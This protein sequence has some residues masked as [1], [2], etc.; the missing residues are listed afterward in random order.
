MKSDG[1]S[2][3]NFPPDLLATLGIP[4]IPVALFT[5]WLLSLRGWQWVAAYCLALLIATVG[6]IYLFRAKLPLYRRHRFFTFGS[7]H[8]P[9]SSIPLYRRGCR[10]SIAG[11]LLAVVLLL[12]PLLCRGF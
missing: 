8:L 12:M 3:R 1:G 7:R 6:A 11:I 2:L 9:P 10:L 4:I 5:S